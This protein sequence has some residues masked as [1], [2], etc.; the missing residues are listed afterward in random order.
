MNRAAGCTT[1]LEAPDRMRVNQRVVGDSSAVG[2]FEN[3]YES[4]TVVVLALVEAE[5]LLI[6]VGL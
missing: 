5:D 4:G 3:L 1:R 6:N 2:A